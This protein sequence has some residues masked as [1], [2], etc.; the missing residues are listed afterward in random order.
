MITYYGHL[1][2][3]LLICTITLTKKVQ[4]DIIVASILASETHN[5]VPHKCISFLRGVDWPEV[6]GFYVAAAVVGDSA[7]AHAERSYRGRVSVRKSDSVSVDF[8]FFLLLL[9]EQIMCEICLYPVAR[10]CFVKHLLM[11]RRGLFCLTVLS[12][13]KRCTSFLEDQQCDTL[14]Y[15]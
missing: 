3:A 4:L 2:F 11:K 12:Q 7:A 8:F 13:K 10:E 6:L 15:I 1:N 14:Y 9:R 5:L